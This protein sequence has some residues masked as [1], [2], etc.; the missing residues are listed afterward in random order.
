[1]VSSSGAFAWFNS[2]DYVS[3]MDLWSVGFICAE[4]LL[5]IPI[6]NGKTET[7][8]SIEPN[9]RGTA[10]SARSSGVDYDLPVD[11]RIVG[12]I[13]TELVVKNPILHGKTKVEASS[14][15]MDSY[16]MMHISL[17]YV[18]YISLENEVIWSEYCLIVESIG[19]LWH[20]P[21]KLL[22]GLTDY[23]LP[24]D[25]RICCFETLL[26][27]SFS[28][29][30]GQG[31]HTNVFK[32]KQIEKGK[33]VALKKVWLN[34]FDPVFEY[35]QHDIVWL[36]GNLDIKFSQLQ[37]KC[38]LLGNPI[39]HGKTESNSHTV[40]VLALFTKSRTTLAV[41]LD[42]RCLFIASFSAFG[43]SFVH[44]YSLLLR[45]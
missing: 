44:L 30:V 21:L 20:R 13:F 29:S 22:L 36:L 3:L 9:K 33:I 39:V 5:R 4:L 8:L 45:L 7:L 6:L 35:M 15:L 40:A 17:V 26:K 43:D 10:T 12:C 23:D 24:V 16:V 28:Y 34:N 38:Y 1:M 27:F 19:T 2:M 14:K 18:I 42:T 32:A 41:F 37:I 25:L 31:K 11:L